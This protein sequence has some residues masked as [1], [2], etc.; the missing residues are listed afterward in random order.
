[1]SQAVGAVAPRKEVTGLHRMT[2]KGLR[3]LC[4]KDKLYQTP[5]LN[6]VLYLHYQGYQY[7]ECLDEYTELKCLWLEC[8]AISEIEGLDKQSKL[9]CLFL[10]NN[11]IKRI[12][13]LASCPELDTLNLSSNHIR[14]IE[15]IGSDILP[16]LNTLN[17]S[18]NYLKDSESLAHLVDCKTLA[19]LDLSNNRIDDI[20]VVKIFEKMPCLKVLVLQG[21]PVV[22]RLPQYRKTLI[23]ACKELT[24]LDSRPVFPRDRAC[25]EAWKRE[26]YEGERKENMRWNRADR[27]KMRDS[28]NYT[29]KLRNRHRPADQQDA[30]ISSTDSETE[31]EAD[32]GAEKTR[33]KAALEY[34][35]VDDMW[36]EVSG[37]NKDNDSSGTS[38]TADEA[39]NGSQADD[40]AEQLSNRQAK[41]LEGRPKVLHESQLADA[42]HPE[43]QLEVEVPQRDDQ[44]TRTGKRIYIEEVKLDELDVERK[45]ARLQEEETTKVENKN[46][47]PKLEE[48]KVDAKPT[49]LEEAVKEEQENS[50]NNEV[51]AKELPELIN[52]PE[53]GSELDQNSAADLEKSSE[54]LGAIASNNAGEPSAEQIKQEC[55][56][57][58]YESYGTEIFA[59]Q[60]EFSATMLEKGN[61]NNEL[62]SKLDPEE[63]PKL[64]SE[65]VNNVVK[66]KEQLEYE[67]EC[68]E[69]NG[70]V[71][72]NIEELSSQLDEDLE[73]L[74]QP[75]DQ[76]RGTPE[77]QA[78]ETNS[79]SDEEKETDKK[80]CIELTTVTRS[81]RIIEEFSVRRERICEDMK[82]QEKRAQDEHENKV[83]IEEM[84][85]EQI[86]TEL[87][88]MDAAFAKALDECTDDVPRRVFGAGCDTP[89]YE[90]RKEECL[91]Q[92]TIKETR[93]VVNED[94][95]Q[96]ELLSAETS[97]AQAELICEEMSKKLAADEAS[98]RELLQEL[99][100]EADVLYD[101]TSTL[102]EENFTKAPE[103][104]VEEVCAALI[105]EL[106]D[107]LQYQ[108]I[109][110]GQNIKCFDFGLIESDEEYSYSAEPKTEK[111]MP[112]ELED[113]AS[114]KSLRECIDAF[115]D[116]LSSVSERKKLGKL[117][118][119]ATSSSDKV[120]AAKELLK[121]RMLTSYKEESPAEL[122]AE[123]AKLEEK[124][125][126]RVAAMATRCFAKREDYE[127]TLDVV[128]NKLVIV[129]KDTGNVEDL[130]P[131]PAL[132]SDSESD[133]EGECSDGDDGD[134]AYDTA[135]ETNGATTSRSMWPKAE[136]E[137]MRTNEE[138]TVVERRDEDSVVDQSIDEFYSLE[139][140]AAFN[141]LDSEFLEK[142][143]LQKVIGSDGEITVEGMRSYDELR[144]GLK[145]ED[146]H[147]EEN[148]G[149]L[150]KQDE[151]LKDLIERKRQQEERERQQEELASSQDLGALKLK[152]KSIMDKLE[153]E[154]EEAGAG[155]NLQKLMCG[156][157]RP[158]ELLGP[159]EEG[160]S[161]QQEDPQRV[162]E[163]FTPIQLT[164]GGCKIYE[165]KSQLPETGNGEE[166]AQETVEERS[167]GNDKCNLE[168]ETVKEA[169][170]QPIDESIE[171]STEKPEDTPSADPEPT[172]TAI[173]PNVSIDDDIIS[174]APSD[175]ESEEEIPVVEPPKLP[176][177]ALNELFS[178]QFEDGQK[179]ERENEEAL[180]K[181]LFSLPLRAWTSQE[182]DSIHQEDERLATGNEKS[183]SESALTTDVDD[184]S[185]ELEANKSSPE[186]TKVVEEDD[187]TD[188]ESNGAVGELARNA[189]R[190]WAK[191]SQKLNEFIAAD[192]MKLLEKSQFN[193][194]ESN[195]E[196]DYELE[197]SLKKLNTIYED[198]ETQIK[199]SKPPNAQQLEELNKAIDKT[200]TQICAEYAVESQEEKFKEN[201]HE[202]IVLEDLDLTIQE[203]TEEFP[204]LTENLEEK[205]KENAH[206]SVVL[207]DLD[208]TIP[209]ATKELPQLT[210]NLEENLKENAHENLDL[211]EVELPIQ[212]VGEELPQSA[213]NP[214]KPIIRLDYFEAIE[215]DNA[216]SA[217]FDTKT[218]L[219]TEE[220]ECNLEI[221]NYDGDAVVQEVSVNAQVTY[222]LK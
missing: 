137:P 55:I 220:I 85:T 95:Y 44:E 2:Q 213:E 75:L 51:E 161:D 191:I 172:K 209:E 143:D 108:E 221:L 134:D 9:K 54:K 34:G 212:Q 193:E 158:K 159:Q 28:V 185:S 197:A 19:V 104:P 135:E 52:E 142:L 214:P 204:Q 72:Y 99:E 38:G 21:N 27:K 168:Q 132:I 92:L 76:L 101:I 68:V 164:L 153:D 162:Q 70:I 160:N 167:D 56:D 63:M 174:D 178:N 48:T 210:E 35:C 49:E 177:G 79:S 41:P 3:D 218:E 166:P 114:G 61:P 139:A 23:L 138:L 111:Q 80:K 40:I 198:C 122:D 94:E 156:S 83:L 163:D 24:Y 73:E 205:L 175:Y 86:E 71:E 124:T 58:M 222:E 147:K 171:T 199:N 7:I 36:S 97:H 186:Q 201:A 53:S 10:Q 183:E 65:V 82:D 150:V 16:V 192:D 43:E 133:S 14:L 11:L 157:E 200:E 140:R 196:D 170:E 100:D 129:K 91:R 81:L 69:A 169:V 187:A 39:S 17:I 15:N 45:R 131:P 25:A 181:Q 66:T 119:K 1:M 78:R 154:I 120:Q 149:A 117:D 190:Q 33:V 110:K 113:P 109:I 96:I 47:D 8:N 20:L 125:K 107:E 29:I 87:D 194:D 195:G 116:F 12:E 102:D 37:D 112:P 115:G 128:D 42:P 182:E 184:E 46:D 31:Q 60:P 118:R 90:W 136:P 32:K 93:S 89:S 146:I 179:L 155:K 103:P 130:P 67:E 62:E 152:T 59:E 88:E 211:E 202:N 98:L 106:I 126:R 145:S 18:S 203:A 188:T 5:R 165:L 57:R 206:E 84:E 189:K 219:K 208:L 207:E 173:N 13:N 4:K 217:D 22:S 77:Y 148:P 127:D 121:S 26:G 123:L 64:R 144:A 215:P 151:M 216:D 6:D 30:L 180:R 50:A 176:E 141:S 74:R 105:D